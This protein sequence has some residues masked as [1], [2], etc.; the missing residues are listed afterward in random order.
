MKIEVECPRC[1]L[2]L[3]LPSREGTERR[4]PNCDLEF[5]V[6]D[7]EALYAPDDAKEPASVECPIQLEEFTVSWR[8]GTYRCPFCKGDI[9]VAL[10]EAPTHEEV[11]EVACPLQS[12]KSTWF[13]EARAKGGPMLC[14]HC[15]TP[16]RRDRDGEWSHGPKI[17]DVP[18][19]APRAKPGGP[20]YLLVHGWMNNGD[21]PPLDR[22]KKDYRQWAAQLRVGM[23]GGDQGSPVARAG[24]P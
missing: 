23:E 17:E 15:K 13:T 24:A 5:S 21:L 20:V 4:C 12:D 8:P 14:G 19:S 7:G 9:H 11:H 1:S 3:E 22:E 18:S 2:D 10:G 16:L 6:K